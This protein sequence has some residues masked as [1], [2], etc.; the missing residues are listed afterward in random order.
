ML[1]RFKQHAKR[2]E[3]ELKVSELLPHLLKQ[4]VLSAE[5]LEDL[6]NESPTEQNQMLLKYIGEKTPF[7][8]VRFAECLRESPDN[9]QLSELLLPGNSV[10]RAEFICVRKEH[11]Y[12]CMYV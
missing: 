11:S 3:E 8:V 2:L 5:E 12:V 1:K 10:S 6:S 4:H 7:W 9:K